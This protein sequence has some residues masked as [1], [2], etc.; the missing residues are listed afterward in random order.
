MAEDFIIKIVNAYSSDNNKTYSEKSLK[1]DIDRAFKILE[2][3]PNIIYD[4]S[5]VLISTEI[6]ESVEA[7]GSYAVI[8]K[9]NV[10]VFEMP[11][12]IVQ[13]K[14]NR[15][16]SDGVESET[17][18]KLYAPLD[19]L[20]SETG[21]LYELTSDSLDSTALKYVIIVMANSWLQL[22]D[23]PPLPSEMSKASEAQ[24]LCILEQIQQR[25]IEDY[26]LEDV[27]MLLSLGDEDEI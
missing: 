16:Q 17:G 21:N 9:F 19:E 22:A 14:S 3:N 5:S 8:F 15:L 11:D 1:K 2:A 25:Y 24:K 12:V 27:D 7:E 23:L 10:T 6:D 13:P 20:T 18:D 4:A 26:N